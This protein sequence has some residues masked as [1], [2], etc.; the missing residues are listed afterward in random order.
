MPSRHTSTHT[1]THMNTFNF[2]S[3]LKN[4]CTTLTRRLQHRSSLH[5]SMRAR[6]HRQAKLELTKPPLSHCSKRSQTMRTHSDYPL[7]PLLPPLPTPIPSPS[8]CAH[9]PKH[10]PSTIASIA[11][12]KSSPSSGSNSNSKTLPLVLQTPSTAPPLLVLRFSTCEN[13]PKQTCLHHIAY[14]KP[15]LTQCY[16]IHQRT[17]EPS[18]TILTRDSLNLQLLPYSASDKFSVV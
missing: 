3:R 5:T 18:R 8:P 17:L 4:P 16:C 1:P 11:A 15:F 2:C 12:A 10:P 9:K 14:I 7:F 13:S 6:T